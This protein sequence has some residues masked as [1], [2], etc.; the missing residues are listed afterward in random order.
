MEKEILAALEIADQKVRLLVGQFYNGRLNILKVEEVAHRG[1]SSY[2]IISESIV[3]EAIIKAVENASRN[4]GVVIEKVIVMLPSVHM[5]H[6]TEQRSIPITGRVSELDVKRAYRE[7]LEIKAPEDYVLTN[8]LMTKFFVNGSSTRKLPMNEKCDRLTIEADLYYGRQSIVFPYLAAV[9]KSGLKILEIVLDDIAIA[10]EA[11]LLEAS[12]DRPVI[13]YTLGWSMSKMS[14][15]YQG[16]LLSNDYD[17]SGYEVFMKKLQSELSVPSDVAERLL[18]H[19]VNLLE[20]KPKDDPIFIWSKQ[21][22]TKTVS[23]KDLADVVRDDIKV[24]IQSLLDRSEPI[25]QLGKPLIVL[26]GEASVIE[27]TVPLIEQSVEADVELYQSISFGA[28]HPKFAALLGTFYFYKDY[29]VYREST[30]SSADL[31][32]FKQ[33]VLDYDHIVQEDESMTQKLK[34]LFFE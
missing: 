22:H 21:A 34:K 30:E 12:I 23:A 29:E 33:K 9:E 11:S 27:G 18:Y 28:K 7:F 14:L 1:V 19:N 3:V 10:K 32:A 8:V 26:S 17:A 2:N 25:F 16:R 6:K 31:E 15:Y 20:D 5:Q 13:S 4:L 24:Y